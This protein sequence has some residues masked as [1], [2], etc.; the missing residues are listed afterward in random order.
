MASES[1]SQDSRHGS[2]DDEE[3][4]DNQSDVLIESEHIKLGDMAK[5]SMMNPLQYPRWRW[6]LGWTLGW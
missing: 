4:N 6:S 1:G 3:G 2:G 5:T